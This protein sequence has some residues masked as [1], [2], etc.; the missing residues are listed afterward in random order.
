MKVYQLGR[1]GWGMFFTG[2]R[3]IQRTIRYHALAVADVFVQVK[4]ASRDGILDILEWQV[5]ADAW[6][7]V[8]GADL[9]P[10]LYL[11]IGLREKRE[12]LSLW[13]EVDLGGERQKQIVEKLDRYAYAYGHAEA[14]PRD[15]FPQVVFLCIDAARA[16]E[17][18]HIIARTHNLPSEL[19]TVQLLADFPRLLL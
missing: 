9:R 7:D 12:R 15:V 3:K 13:L 4:Q 16:H 8:A 6:A 10:D 5:E 18:R 11:D 14:Y 1:E 17:L 2:K 19:V